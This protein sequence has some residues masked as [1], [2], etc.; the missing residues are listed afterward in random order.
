MSTSCSSNPRYHPLIKA[1][2]FSAVLR[3]KFN[4]T[5]VRLSDI[6]GHRFQFSFEHIP[7][8]K[9]FS[10]RL[11]F[12]PVQSDI[13]FSMSRC[14]YLY[15]SDI[16]KM[17]EEPIIEKNVFK[18]DTP[19]SILPVYNQIDFLFFK[20]MVTNTFLF[21]YFLHMDSRQKSSKSLKILH[22]KNFV[23][24]STLYRHHT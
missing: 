23:S 9:K 18:V 4:G 11:L 12:V 2:F 13:L 3:S 7:K 6:T 24:K 21:Y 15:S 14:G 17:N 1:R 5:H 20:T 16:Y 22:I 8:A 10:L 19:G